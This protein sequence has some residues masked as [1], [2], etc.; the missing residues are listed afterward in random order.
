MPVDTATVAVSIISSIGGGAIVAF[1]NHRLTMGRE[2]RK[3][4]EDLTL[5][6]RIDAYKKLERAS[7]TGP[8]ASLASEVREKLLVDFESAY[9]ETLLL[10][11]RR[12]IELAQELAARLASSDSSALIPLLD[13]IRRNLR[14]DMGLETVSIGEKRFLRFHR[15]DHLP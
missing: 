4:F 13:E 8:D 3:R 7:Q 10:G 6:R 11:T 9:A 14:S 5:Q 15:S 2:R 1:V 12:E